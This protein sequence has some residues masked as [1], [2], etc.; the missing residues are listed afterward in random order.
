[1]D[2]AKLYMESIGFKEVKRE[3]N[4]P[5]TWEQCESGNSNFARPDAIG[6]ARDGME[7]EFGF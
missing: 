4:D 2:D 6:S 1:M 3:C 7:G 5:Y